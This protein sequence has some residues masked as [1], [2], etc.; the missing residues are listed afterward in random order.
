MFFVIEKIP[1]IQI[2]I[3]VDL[4]PLSFFLIA[5]K[6]SLIDR[7]GFLYLNTPSMSLLLLDLAEVYFSFTLYQF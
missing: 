2:T 5:K 1:N 4:N 7:T 3:A 6:L